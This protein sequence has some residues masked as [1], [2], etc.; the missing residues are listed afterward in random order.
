MCHRT[1]PVTISRSGIGSG[2]WELGPVRHRTDPVHLETQHFLL[3]GIFKFVFTPIFLWSYVRYLAPVLCKCTLHE[4]S[5]GQ[6]IHPKPPFVVR[7]K[8]NKS[9]ITKLS[10]QWLLRHLE[11]G[12]NDPFVSFLSHFIDV[13]PLGCFHLLK[14]D[15]LHYDLTYGIICRIYVSHNNFKLLV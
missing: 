1:G 9:P 4:T 14:L 13:H 15:F 7:L 2:L 8:A 12:Y 10:V 5:L 6:V 3:F 11:L